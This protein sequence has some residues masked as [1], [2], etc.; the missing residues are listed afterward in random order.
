MWR[1]LKADGETNRKQQNGSNEDGG[2]IGKRVTHSA[3]QVGTRSEDSYMNC[4]H[5]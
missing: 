3:L 4:F 1:V 5:Y 2:I